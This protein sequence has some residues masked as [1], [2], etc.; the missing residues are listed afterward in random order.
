MKWY[1]CPYC[2]AKQFLM[3]DGAVVKGIQI[4]CRQCRKLIEVTVE[5]MSH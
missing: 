2:G 1:F 4:K 5:P 3:R